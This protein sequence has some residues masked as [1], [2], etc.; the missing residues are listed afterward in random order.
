MNL[1]PDQIRALR[2][3]AETEAA[4]ALEAWAT[5]PDVDRMIEHKEHHY[6]ARRAAR[7]L[8]RMEAAQ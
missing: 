4:E 2:Q 7:W 5:T 1:T 6:D 8:A 3:R